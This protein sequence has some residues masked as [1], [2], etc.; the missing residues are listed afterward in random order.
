MKI[1]AQLGVN[2]SWLAAWTRTRTRL[3]RWHNNSPPPTSCP[4]S[5]ARSPA[6]SPLSSLPGYDW[7][8]SDSERF[9][10]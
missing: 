2:L 5:E 6:R 10:S 7:T 3:R 1:L 8:L 4:G 9:D